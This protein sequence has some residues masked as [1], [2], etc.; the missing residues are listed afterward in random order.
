MKPSYEELELM[1]WKTTLEL[2]R[3]NA[4][5]AAMV[6]NELVPKIAQREGDLLK[7]EHDNGK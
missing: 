6:E 4:R 7:K 5:M 2:A 1:L 3:A